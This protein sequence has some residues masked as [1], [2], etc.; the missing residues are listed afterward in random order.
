MRIF[1]G[2]L[3]LGS[4]AGI[5]I[6]FMGLIVFK[7]KNAL[8]KEIYNNKLKKDSITEDKEEKTID[9]S[10]VRKVA[11]EMRE[12][13]HT[14]FKENSILENKG[15]QTIDISIIRKA[16]EEMK[17][18]KTYQYFNNILLE[19]RTVEII[20]KIDIL[21]SRKDLLT[22]ENSKLILEKI[23]N[24]YIP[25]LITLFNNTPEEQLNT[26]VFNNQSIIE[27]IED[28]LNLVLDEINRIQIDITKENS[29]SV[30]I[31]SKTLESL[32]SDKH[33]I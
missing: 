27:N 11:K 15:E 28:N 19:Q 30:I 29:Q 32:F 22:F 5:I 3:F 25:R 12:K 16:A 8:M 31:I 21:L 7:I 10:I 18:K 20:N 14:K 2:L 24:Q 4:I 9:V 13:P 1:F 17:N 33:I 23:K 26:K 6:F